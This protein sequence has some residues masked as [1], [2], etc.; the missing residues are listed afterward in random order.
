MTTEA[1]QQR[2]HEASRALIQQGSQALRQ[3][4][5]QLAQRAL[6]E[7]AIILD[8]AFYEENEVTKLRAQAFNELGVVH[9]RAGDLESSRGFHDQS[10]KMC[11]ILL[12]NGV[13]EFRG[14]SAATHLNLASVCATIGDM[15]AANT[16]AERSISVVELMLEDAGEGVANLGTASYQTLASVRAHRE[17]VAGAG[18]AMRRAIELAQ[19][20]IDAGQTSLYANIAQGCQQLSVI[21]FQ[22]DEFDSAFEWGREAERLSETAFE[23]VGQDT[24]PIYI[25]SQINLISFSE[26][27]G[28]FS[29]AEDSLWKA[30]EVIGN[31]A[32]LL[33]RGKDFYEYCRKQADKRLTEGDLPRAEVESGYADLLERI[34]EIGGIPD[35]LEDPVY[36]GDDEP[37]AFLTSDDEGESE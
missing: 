31:D 30:V 5:L 15:D 7:A 33:K 2:H 21:L 32:R 12:E 17:D 3:N 20:G 13:D 28:K 22:N 37:Q 9:Q 27:T 19:I 14:N 24:L 8:M 26:Q 18:E 16:A 34:E 1:W 4:D 36:E 35:D 6:S 11:D 23:E 25:V 29:A 10:A